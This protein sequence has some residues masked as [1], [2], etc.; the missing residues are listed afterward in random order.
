MIWRQEGLG[1]E[2]AKLTDL[3]FYNRRKDRQTE[4]SD[5]LLSPIVRKVLDF[6]FIKSSDTKFSGHFLSV[7]EQ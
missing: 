7:A 5:I 2:R 4:R 1:R 6:K 3:H